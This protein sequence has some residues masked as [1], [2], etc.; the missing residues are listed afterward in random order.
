MTLSGITIKWQYFSQRQTSSHV[1]GSS[2]TRRRW[3]IDLIVL[4]VEHIGSGE[5]GALF[6]NRKLHKDACYPHNIVM[7]YDKILFY[8]R[9]C[10][11]GDK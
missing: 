7:P 6:F 3:K 5:N 9:S 10:R 8:D 11:F 4:N 1:S 2:F